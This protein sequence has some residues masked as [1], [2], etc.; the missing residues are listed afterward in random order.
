MPSMFAARMNMNRV[1]TKGK[2]GRPDSPR[3]SR[4]MLA[5]NS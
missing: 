2:N 3:I 5:M 4:I 1:N